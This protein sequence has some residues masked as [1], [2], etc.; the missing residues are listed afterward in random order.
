MKIYLSIAVM[1][2]VCVVALTL[3]D[4]H[5]LESFFRR[6]SDLQVIAQLESFS[7]PIMIKK[8]NDLEYSLIKDKQL[9]Q[10]LSHIKS[11][12]PDSWAQI[13]FTSGGEI[14]ISGNSE[15][16][17]EKNNHIQI[18]KTV[19]V[20]LRYGTYKILERSENLVVFEPKDIGHSTELISIPQIQNKEMELFESEKFKTEQNNKLEVVTSAFNKLKKNKKNLNTLTNDEIQKVVQSKKGLFQRCYLQHLKSFPLSKGSLHISFT[21]E[22]S[23]EVSQTKIV[24]S[25]LNDRTLHHCIRTVFSRSQFKKFNAS[26]IIA[27]YPISFE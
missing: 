27:Q 2:A 6:E 15:I 24:E 21:I 3:K 14:E 19:I 20:H 5:S 18:D 11:E 26:P 25:T 12:H 9:I 8:N 10:N 22:P 13:R 7:G 17:I 16:V 23:G 4:R 1:I